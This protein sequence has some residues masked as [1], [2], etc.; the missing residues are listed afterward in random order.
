MKTILALSAMLV[1]T[2]ASAASTGAQQQ[3]QPF[4]QSVPFSRIIANPEPDKAPTIHKYSFV[5]PAGGTSSL[6]AV[7]LNK[8]VHLMVA[9]I[10]SGVRGVGEATL[11]SPSPADF[12]EWVGFDYV[13]KAFSES[14]SA[15]AGTHM[16]WADF[17][18]QVDVQVGDA[19][20]IQ[21][22]NGATTTRT[23]VLYLID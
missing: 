10:T 2:S 9:C 5:I 20:D 4:Q 11:L 22:H 15:T 12:V 23:V 19:T 21:I 3:T 18:G 1:A 17:S 7:P 13:T 6:I 8:P 14:Y 16:I